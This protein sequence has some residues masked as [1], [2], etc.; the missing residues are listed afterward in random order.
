MTWQNFVALAVFVG[1]C[2][3]IAYWG[4]ILGRR[5]GKRRLTLFGLRPRYTAIV[6]TTITGMLIAILTI[7]SLAI[8]NKNFQQLILQGHRIIIEYNQAREEYNQVTKQLA[9]QQ[10]ITKK[11]TKE[12]Q[13]AI[14]A[15]DKLAKEIARIDQNLKTLRSQ[16]GRSKADLA[17]TEADLKAARG[18]LDTAERELADKRD[19]VRKQES[20]IEALKAMRQELAIQKE[21]W[22]KGYS[23]LRAGTIIFRPN[24]DIAWRVI[25][26]AQEKNEIRAE[27]YGLLGEASKV[28]EDVGAKVGDNGR[29]VII[30]PIVQVFEGQERK[31]TEADIVNYIADL[32]YSGS[33]SV[34][35]RVYSITNSFEGE[36]TL[37]DCQPIA[38]RLIYLQGD[39]VASTVIDG[40]L[41][42][43]E[44]VYALVTFLQNDVSSAARHK[45]VIPKYTETGPSVGEIVDVDDWNEVF[46]MVLKIKSAGKKVN[47]TAVAAKETWSVGPML[48]DYVINDLQ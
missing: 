36:Q 14:K 9:S 46:D 23:E 12:A 6:T 11:A 2:G 29:A 41:S 32:I 21:A 27:L 34:V 15:R 33:G 5:M 47:L 42:H 30:R 17:R 18:N 26:C 8:V 13:D 16:L 44:V 10:Q 24:Q 22:N 7:A 1:V 28:A 40:S 43:G 19:Q 39:E 4:D 25:R 45:G 38:N 35:A 48:V 31:F 20:A 3:F 37:V